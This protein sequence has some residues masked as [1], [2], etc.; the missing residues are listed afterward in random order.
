MSFAERYEAGDEEKRE[1]AKLAW[2]ALM[3]TPGMGPTRIWK[4]MGRL[5]AAERAQRAAQ[6]EA[7][8]AQHGRRPQRGR[9]LKVATDAGSV[10]TAIQAADQALQQA[11]DAAWVLAV[12]RD[13][14]RPVDPRTGH[15]RQAAAVAAD[16]HT[17]AALLREVGGPA[18]TAATLLDRRAAGL[19]AYLA[20]LDHALAGPRAVLGEQDLCFLAWAWHHRSSLGLTDAA[21]AWP[22]AP[23]V[24]AQ[25][26]AALDGAVRASGMV[27]NLNSVLA[28]HRAAHR[29]L[30]GP[31]LAVFQVYRNQR[32]FARG[33]RA[34]HSPCDLAGCAS[35]HW[36]DALGYGRIAPTAEREFPKQARQTVTT[37]AA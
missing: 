20:A 31:L 7:Y 34:G 15:V 5:E 24:A 19:V 17:A 4:A 22:H 33:R 37:L 12:V 6:A 28:P 23:V 29:G 25:V 26:W 21:Q 9:P 2:M 10:Q 30:P 14:L 13:V 1:L 18:T 8:R 3:L 11:D 36:L 32:V 16:L 35:T 27:E